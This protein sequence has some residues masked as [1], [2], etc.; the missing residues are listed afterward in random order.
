MD[1]LQN[2]VFEMIVIEK[3]GYCIS[4]MKAIVGVH[5]EVVRKKTSCTQ[6]NLILGHS[7]NF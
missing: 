4:Q 5:K 6:L 7:I 3:I 2:I 1:D